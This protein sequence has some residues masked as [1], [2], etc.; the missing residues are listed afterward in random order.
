[1]T[2]TTAPDAALRKIFALRDRAAHANTPA[3]EAD[4]AL[5]L[6]RKLCDKHGLSHS[7]LE[8]KTAAPRPTTTNGQPSKPERT[9]SCR[10]GCSMFTQHTAAEMSACADKARARSANGNAY[11]SKQRDPFEN[12]FRHF[13]EERDRT[14][15]DNDNARSYGY[16][17]DAPKAKRNGSHAYC[18]HEATKSARAKCRR[19]R[20]H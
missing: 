20:G 2:T 12:L 3:A 13:Y 9:Y 11:E 7:L 15:R 6:A 17:N 5:A 16:E 18:S 19:E 10:F 8:A 4:T 14:S 1:M